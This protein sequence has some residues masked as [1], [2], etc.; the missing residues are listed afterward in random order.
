MSNDIKELNRLKKNS[1]LYRLRYIQ[2]TKLTKALYQTLMLKVKR[3]SQ[4]AQKCRKTN[5]NQI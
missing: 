3:I 5:K 1:Q 4:I 2:P